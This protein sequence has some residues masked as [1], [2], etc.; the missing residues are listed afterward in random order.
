MWTQT[1]DIFSEKVTGFEILDDYY[2]EGGQSAKSTAH[3]FGGLGWSDSGIAS[4]D[5]RKI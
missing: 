4:F 3:M 1:S 5:V 2:G